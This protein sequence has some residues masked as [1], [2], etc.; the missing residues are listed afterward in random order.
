MIR[1][2]PFTPADFPQLQA[3]IDSKQLLHEWSGALFSFPLSDDALH[4]Y[5]ED[6]NV[7][8]KSDVF[9][10]KAVETATG[11][12]VGH[13]SLGNVSPRDQSARLTRVL[14]GDPGQRGR[15]I[16]TRM[17]RE[18]LRIGF[19]ELGLHR[20]SLGVYSFNQAAIRSYLRAGFQQEGILRDVVKYGDEFWSSVEMSV[21]APE[22]RA[23]QA[24]AQSA[25]PV[26]STKSV[27][28]L[29]PALAAASAAPLLS[30]KASPIKK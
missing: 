3:W 25:A 10:Y 4:W 17:I 5:L 15:G 9:I 1:L 13:I 12:A 6:S 7:P 2:E 8:G 29:S 16:S 28:Q 20:I 23:G 24:A 30:Q 11:V 22:W 27:V 21:L 19:T 14:V 26:V 18:V